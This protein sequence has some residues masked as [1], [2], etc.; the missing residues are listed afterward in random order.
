MFTGIVVSLLLFSFA[1]SLCQ[2][3]TELLK[4][5]EKSR[6]HDQAANS[7]KESI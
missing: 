4:P 1:R 7:S 5:E 3:M 2:K 6:R